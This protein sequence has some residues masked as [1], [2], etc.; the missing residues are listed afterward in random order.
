MGHSAAS[1]R[2][3]RRR[4][5]KRERQ[6]ATEPSATENAVA[7][8]EADVERTDDADVTGDVVGSNT[9]DVV[10][11]WEAS[12]NGETHPSTSSSSGLAG[13]PL[14]RVPCRTDHGPRMDDD[15]D[16]RY[17]DVP[18]EGVDA[19]DVPDPPSSGSNRVAEGA[20]TLVDD[21]DVI[22]SSSE[23]LQ[24]HDKKRRRPPTPPR[25]RALQTQAHTDEELIPDDYAGYPGQGPDEPRLAYLR[26][27]LRE[28]LLESTHSSTDW[29][30]SLYGKMLQSACAQ[31]PFFLAMLVAVSCMLSNLLRSLRRERKF[32][33]L[34]T[35][36]CRGAYVRR[37]WPWTVRSTAARCL[38]AKLS[39]A[40]R[41]RRG[42][43]VP[44][45]PQDSR[46]ARP[47]PWSTGRRVGTT[48]HIKCRQGSKILC[49]STP[50]YDAPQVVSKA[51]HTRQA[52]SP[53]THS[54]AS[55][56][57]K[58]GGCS[59]G[60]WR[61]GCCW[62]LRLIACLVCCQAAAAV[63]PRVEGRVARPSEVN[64]PGSGAVSHGAT[65][66]SESFKQDVTY[67]THTLS[68]ETREPAF[69]KR[70]FIRALNRVQQHGQ[71]WYRGRLHTAAT[72]GNPRTGSVDEPS[73]DN[74]CR[75]NVQ[76]T[77]HAKNHWRGLCWNAG[78][79]SS[80]KLA[81]IELWLAG[82]RQQGLT[83]QA[84]AIQETHWSFTSEWKG[85]EY[86]CIHSGTGS[87]QGGLLLMLHRSF[88][89]DD[90]I[91]VDHVV[92][93]RLMHVR[94]SFEPALEIITLY[95]HC[96][97]RSGP[98]GPA[99][100]NA[101][102]SL[103][104]KRERVWER[105][106]QV[107][108]RV[109][110]RSLVVVWGDFNTECRPDDP[111]IGPGVLKADKPVPQTD[112]CRLE[113]ILHRFGL[114]TLNSW[115]RRGSCATFLS[116]TKG[117]T[118]ATQID[119]VLTRQHHSTPRSRLARP[120]WR[121]PF[122]PTS[123]MRH[124]PIE[125]WLPTPSK[126]HVPRGQRTP[127]PSHQLI[128]QALSQSPA[129]CAQLRAAVSQTLSSGQLQPE[130][131]PT[132]VINS[133]LLRGWAQVSGRIERCETVDAPAPAPTTQ[134]IRDLWQARSSLRQLR[135]GAISSLF[136]GWRQ[137]L[138]IQRLQKELHRRCKHN[139][140]DRV[141]AQLQLAEAS[142]GPAGIYQVVK[143]LAPKSRRLRVQ[144][145][146]GE[147]AL[148]SQDGELKAIT[149]YF[150]GIYGPDSHMHPPSGPMSRFSPDEVLAALHKLQ[151]RKAL[152]PQS[153]PAALWRVCAAE[154]APGIHRALEASLQREAPCLPA[155]WHD[156]T[157]CLIP[158][159]SEVRMP[160]QLRP[161]C[162]LPPGSKIL[163]TMLADKLRER[164]ALYMQAIPQFA[165]LPQR[166][167]NDALL[168]VCSHL[169]LV[170]DLASHANPS[171]HAKHA[172]AK[173]Q[174]LRGGVALSLDINKAF[175]ALPRRYLHQSLQRAR[176]PE[177]D[178]NLILHIHDAA[179]MVYQVGDK[180][181][182]VNLNQGIRQGCS[183]SPL[184]WAVS[185]AS[186]YLDL[187]KNLQQ[188]SLP[189]GE[190]TMYADDIFSAWAL[191]RLSDLAP[192][193]RAM[194]I[195]IETLEQA[196][197]SLSLE[198][199]AALMCLRGGAAQSQLAKVCRKDSD[200][201]RV[202]QI[203]V[204]QR[205]I[206]VKVKTTHL[207]LG[208]Q[209]SYQHYELSNL[210]HRMQVA[211]G[212]FWRLHSIL[213]SRALTLRTKIRLWRTCV[214]SALRYSLVSVGQP[215]QGRALITTM[216]NKQLRMILKSPAH[217]RR[218][219][220]E[221][222]RTAC[223]VDDPWCM[224]QADLAN[225]N[226]L[227]RLFHTEHLQ[228]W[229]DRIAHSYE[230]VPSSHDGEN[231]QN[232]AL[233]HPVNSVHHFRDICCPVCGI[234]FFSLYA[235]KSH[236][237][238]EHLRAQPVEDMDPLQD[239]ILD[240]YSDVTKRTPVLTALPKPLLGTDAHTQFVYMHALGG[241]A[242][243]VHCRR[244]CK[245]WH[246]LAVHI[247]SRSC[248]VL[249][250]DGLVMQAPAQNPNP[251]PTAFDPECQQQ[252]RRGWEH[253][254]KW[255]ALQGEKWLHHCPWCMQWIADTKA[256][257]IHISAKHPW[258]ETCYVR[259]KIWQFQQRK[260]LVL[261]SPC[262][263]CCRTYKGHPSKHTTECKSLLFAH[264]LAQQSTHCAQENDTQ[265]RGAREEG[266]GRCYNGA[267]T[268]GVQL[269]ADAGHGGEPH[270][271]TT[272]LHR[273]WPRRGST[274][275]KVAE[276]PVQ[277]PERQREGD[278]ERPAE[279][280]VSERPAGRRDRDILQWLG[281][282]P[283]H[284]SDAHQA[285]APPRRSI[286]DVPFVNGV[287]VLPVSGEAG[288]DHRDA[289]RDGHTVE[290]SETQRPRLAEQSDAS[291][292]VSGYV[293]NAP[294]ENG[295]H[296][297]EG[298][299]QAAGHRN[300]PLRRVQGIPVPNLE[301]KGKESPDRREQGPAAAGQGA[302]AD[303][304]AH[305]AGDGQRSG[306]QISLHTP[307]DG[308]HEGQDDNMAD[309]GGAARQPLQPHLGDPSRVEGQRLVEA[310]RR[311]HSRGA[312]PENSAR[313]DACPA[314]DE[315]AR[316][317][318]ILLKLQNPS[319]FCYSHACLL[320]YLWTAAA[321]GPLKQ[322]V[323]H[324]AVLQLLQNILS[325]AQP[326]NLWSKI[327]WRQALRE[328]SQPGRQH[329]AADFLLVL[330]RQLQADCFSTDWL[331]F[332]QE[333]GG[334]VDT[335]TSC[336]LALTAVHANA[337]VPESRSR[338]SETVSLQNVV[339]LWH[340]QTA[341][342]ALASGAQACALQLS[343]FR[344]VQGTARKV[345]FHASIP[346]EIQIPVW[347]GAG[348]LHTTYCLQAMIVHLGESMHAGRYRSVLVRDD[349]RWYY[350]NDNAEAVL[351]HRDT[352]FREIAQ[353]VYIAFYARK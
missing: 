104:E 260:S 242:T 107:L 25:P 234:E 161:I 44:P 214:F 316:R 32:R 15:D 314:P 147:S 231:K 21:A 86:W 137:A 205:R 49:V 194:G 134:L 83:V 27:C 68:R 259:A 233:L 135:R 216:V 64:S 169:N 349:R 90:Q 171:L 237:T 340:R 328:W 20:A 238:K 77:P 146:D 52:V 312:P 309:G 7:P 248:R 82:Q 262:R 325:A 151:P 258:L 341:V 57:P 18:A 244:M 127:R 6:A 3:Q 97:Q 112:Y 285:P 191:R 80:A 136:T 196:G 30:K 346:H 118:H 180:Q 11:E 197:L 70:S 323:K 125:A 270:G 48:A 53:I 140:R 79:L 174:S 337:S 88:V 13:L 37:Q 179:R 277:G 204:F 122:V 67:Q 61:P 105:L 81:E 54:R 252:F 284:H 296:P 1:K 119:F 38:A 123:G 16:L 215:S 91:R 43:C 142:K 351:V 326:V 176:I 261:C 178:I 241:M 150:R 58:P 56:G 12:T 210:Q 322:A 300:G 228:T 224:L 183:L 117:K 352:D 139:K 249:F 78:G 274:A 265:P 177:A 73:M 339:T 198:K 101:G 247:T 168:R 19:E 193:V 211:W 235:M 5:G 350:T 164:I 200:G 133:A 281:A 306:H 65:K 202:L 188:A 184:L 154:V 222:V 187:V 331:A 286:G 269:P 60:T 250:P 190:P 268:A 315:A 115:S 271:G 92:P 132:E 130:D 148:M 76:P 264:M 223:R 318:L 279:A 10:N 89:G 144:I 121:L 332:H 317:Q 305:E 24:T 113:G 128:H 199:T 129:L 245:S 203:R 75:H 308:R 254:A 313:T 14:T 126:K 251:L 23:E 102:A 209:I 292:L 100:Q 145:R 185:T 160:K 272:G 226:S 294:H 276:G 319:N 93:G 343:R 219:T 95:Q 28:A 243:C 320:A 94:L 289:L 173:T 40:Q 290:E 212:T 33:W 66:N 8:P 295:E 165:Y 84:L 246:D 282:V 108:H 220:A 34:V 347:H 17:R 87:R 85:D 99:N 303:S 116:T 280:P 120:L 338:V 59:T 239:L 208:A 62:M 149:D 124:L 229:L 253:G 266:A 299:R 41:R 45:R 304:G 156:I 333:H 166:S 302:R 162:L 110:W 50:A 74:P 29:A 72:I 227:P 31:R 153:A 158:K 138:R 206:R 36:V 293:E 186:L 288:G 348:V 2:R 96:W 189:I 207:Y 267:W 297:H 255:I 344:L 232:R 201:N 141:E 35:K 236:M 71:T 287:G 39:T 63:K 301:C 345:L 172:G 327:P 167:A 334:C 240:M 175:D 42:N 155:S 213:R 143:R 291:H 263:Y 321:F 256:M 106:Q 103:E 217:I 157:V 273:Y 51:C 307:P 55:P 324:Q 330:D 9:G 22:S 159:V 298:G 342:H 98:A 195:L 109:P 218:T 69:R 329:D 283:R 131:E 163:A 114:T 275:G 221:Q 230:Q 257:H 152:P 310:D 47:Q 111:F 225:R 278:D 26:R 4:P 170:R 182:C 192:A 335:G 336:P 181:A 46:C 353:N 311:S